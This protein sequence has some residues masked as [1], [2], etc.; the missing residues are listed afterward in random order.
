MRSD[1]PVG[2]T[3]SQGWQIGVSRTLPISL[4]KAWEMILDALELPSEMIQQ[5]QHSYNKGTVLETGSAT[6][7]E[8]RSHEPYSLLRMKWHP[9]GWSRSS[10]LQIRVRP[11][12]TGTTISVHH[13]WLQDAEHR[14][15]MRRHWTEVLEVL[16]L[17]IKHSSG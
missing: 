8:I 17:A 7:I 3:K 4:E 10:T 6:R 13:E 5:Q 12:K 14:E 1:K 2:Q 9:K 16:K 15:A 11:A